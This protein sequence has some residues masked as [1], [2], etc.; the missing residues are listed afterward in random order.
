M[1]TVYRIYPKYIEMATRSLRSHSDAPT[2]KEE[3]IIVSDCNDNMLSILLRIKRD[4]LYFSLSVKSKSNF[5]CYRN[6]VFALDNL[7][8]IVRTSNV[9]HSHVIKMLVILLSFLNRYSFNNFEFQIF[10][11]HE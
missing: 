5:V 7:I 4:I 10:N 3:E 1:I 11:K 6:F 9:R 2:I 8:N